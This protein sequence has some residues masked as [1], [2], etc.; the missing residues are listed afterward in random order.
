MATDPICGMDVLP[1]EAAGTS[2]YQG[3]DYYFCAVACKE[4]FDRSP[5]QNVPNSPHPPFTKGG[6]GGISGAK[7]EA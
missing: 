3:V 6:H 7:P 1:E 5:E 4:A 2:R